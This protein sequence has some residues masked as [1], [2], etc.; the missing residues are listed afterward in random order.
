MIPRIREVR[1]GN[2]KSIEQA[3]VSLSGMTVLVGANG[4]GKS[5]FVDAL[6]FVNKAPEIVREYCTIREA[7]EEKHAFEL[8]RGRFTKRIPGTRD[9]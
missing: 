9:V 6:A 7:G 1:I 4:S 8:E 3:V 2:D 5:N